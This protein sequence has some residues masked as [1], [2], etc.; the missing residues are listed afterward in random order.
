MELRFVEGN[1][2]HGKFKLQYREPHPSAYIKG[3]TMDGPWLDVPCVELK[4]WC[5]HM[6]EN[7]T[8]GDWKYCP[9][10]GAVKP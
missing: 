10:C 4:K 2:E 6:R 1:F 3:G 7:L 5:E 8:P 9:Y